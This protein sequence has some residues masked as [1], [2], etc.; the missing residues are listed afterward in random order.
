MSTTKEHQGFE[1]NMSGQSTDVLM[2]QWL[3][4]LELPTTVRSLVLH[5]SVPT[6]LLKLQTGPQ[7]PKKRVRMRFLPVP[8]SMGPF[9]KTEVKG[10]SDQ[11]FF[12]RVAVLWGGRKVNVL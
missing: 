6:S 3:S 8:G 5:G 7:P 10:T 1:H 12:L 4:T 11:D 2:A 9:F